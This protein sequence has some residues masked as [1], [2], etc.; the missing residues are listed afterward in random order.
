MTK[1]VKPNIEYTHEE[2]DFSALLY[3]KFDSQQI[4]LLADHVE[5]LYEYQKILSL[6]IQHQERSIATLSKKMLERFPE[7]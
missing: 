7:L 2:L 5:G 6:E 1:R 4:K 3:E